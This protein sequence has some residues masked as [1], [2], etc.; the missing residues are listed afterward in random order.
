MPAR[1]RNIFG[2]LLLYR[3]RP[4]SPTD[5]VPFLY[6]RHD[7]SRLAIAGKRVMEICGAHY[8]DRMLNSFPYAPHLA[9]WL[10]HYAGT[11][12]GAMMFSSG[13]GKVMS[14]NDTLRLIRKL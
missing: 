4:L 9:F 8:E 3:T 2:T 14:T 11:T 1:T 5:P 6:T 12:F 7:L 10:T 13:G